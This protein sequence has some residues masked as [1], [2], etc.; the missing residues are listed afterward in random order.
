MTNAV[1]LERD[2]LTSGTTWHTAGLV[3]RLRPN[4]TDV[5]LIGRTHEILQELENETGID[6]GWINNGGLFIA[7]NRE[8]LDEYKRLHTFGK[9]FGIESHVLDPE[10]TKKLYPLMNVDDV[11]ATLYSPAD[12]TV[13]PNGFCAALTRFAT[14][15]GA[16]VIE[17]CSVENILS[18][19]GTFK[20]RRVSAVVTNRGTIKTNNV[21]NCTGVWANHVSNKVGTVHIG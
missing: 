16:K 15:A 3:W 18:E 7:N 1:L 21:V 5:R 6:P 12:G 9:A 8:R 20:S 2:K 4:E 19:E 11:F 17:G 13:D 14:K 10:E